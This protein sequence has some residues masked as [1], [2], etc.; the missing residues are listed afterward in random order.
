MSLLKRIQRL[1]KPYMSFY[2]ERMIGRRERK[3]ELVWLKREMEADKEGYKE[4]YEAGKKEGHKQTKEE[5]GSWDKYQ[6]CKEDE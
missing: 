3:I 6:S 1:W 4:G 2:G 5:E